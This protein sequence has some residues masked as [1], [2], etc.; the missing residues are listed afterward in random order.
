MIKSYD[1]KKYFNETFNQNCIK[2]IEKILEYSICCYRYPMCEHPSIQ[3][4]NTLFDANSD[5]FKI[6]KNSFLD[7]L[8]LYLNKNFKIVYFYHW[9]YKVQQNQKLQTLGLYH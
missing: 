3:S 1:C 2:E 7:T 4:H 5:Y 9:V 6:L 8:K